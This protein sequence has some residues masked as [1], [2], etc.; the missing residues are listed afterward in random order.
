MATLEHKYFNLLLTLHE[1]WK[2][3][4]RRLGVRVRQD[5]QNSCSNSLK[6]CS[7]DID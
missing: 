4:S 3:T 2:L 1:F 6:Y 5:A 7:C